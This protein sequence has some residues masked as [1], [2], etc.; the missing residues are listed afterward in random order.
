MEIQ[1]ALLKIANPYTVVEEK[2]KKLIITFWYAMTTVIN[3]KNILF[4]LIN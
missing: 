2:K 3:A 1:E 4:T